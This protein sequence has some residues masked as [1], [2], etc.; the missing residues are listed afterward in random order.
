MDLQR[1]GFASSW[2]LSLRTPA[3]VSL[4]TAR[5]GSYPRVSMGRILNMRDRALQ[6]QDAIEL[7]ASKWRIPILHLLRGG[8]LRT[9][10][11]QAAI[12]EISPKMLTQTLRGMERD[13]LI[14]RKVHAV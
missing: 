10:D 1:S 11:L 3:P 14:A 12:T 5:C 8:T 13:G 6:S 9:G 4:R 7:L 2:P